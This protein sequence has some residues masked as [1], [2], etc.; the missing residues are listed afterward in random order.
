MDQFSNIS[1]QCSPSDDL[2]LIPRGYADTRYA[3]TVHVHAISDVTELTDALSARVTSEALSTILA[4]Y[5]T[6]TDLTTTLADYA[7][8][9]SVTSTL[10]NYVTGTALSTT[11]ASYATTASVTTALGDLAGSV[12]ATY[13]TQAS[14]AGYSV[15]SHQHTVEPVE[16]VPAS[17]II[18]LARDKTQYVKTI[19]GNTVIGFNA[20]ALNLGANDAATFELLI[21][22]GAQVRQVLFGGSV[23]WLNGEEPYF[24]AAN[25]SYLFAFRTYDGGN[26]WVGAYQGSF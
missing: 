10:E 5:V 11:L 1:L 3:A 15:T 14:L 6:D 24:N 12:A 19:T 7:T 23:T 18:T 4:D 2:H 21:K 16:A 25:R 20:S 9:A 22:M 13:A 8:T 26:S 17:G